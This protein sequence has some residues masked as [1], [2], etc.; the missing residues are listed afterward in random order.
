MSFVQYLWQMARGLDT[1]RGSIC[2][3]VS[4]IATVDAKYLA[5]TAG[6]TARYQTRGDREI[7]RQG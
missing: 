7:A 4:G 1:G 6:V 2:L 3:G 5:V